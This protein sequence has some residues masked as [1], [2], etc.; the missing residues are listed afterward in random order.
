MMV[1]SFVIYVLS[2][3]NICYAATLRDTEPTCGYESCPAVKDDMIN[4][5]LV[6]HTHDDVGW[7]KTVDQYYYGARNNIQNAG[8]QY[9]LDSVIPELLNDP[10]KRFIY[11]E[12]AFFARWWR[13]QDD[14]MRHIVKGL[15]NSGR[16]EFILGG[17][18]MNDEASTHYNAIIDQ[19][20]LGFE[21]LRQNFGECGRP[22]IGWQIDPFGHSREQASL[23]AQFGFDGLFFGRLDF[24][25]KEERMKELTMEM[26]W[27]GSPNNLGEKSDLFTGVLFNGYS[28]PGGFCFDIF[29]QDEPIKDNKQLHDYNVDDRVKDFIKAV[30]SQAIHYKTNHI[31]MTMGSDFQYQ[32][33]HHWYKNMDKL[34]KYTNMLQ[35]TNHSNINVL[36]STPSCYLNQLNKAGIKWP[37]K[38]DDFFPYAHRNHSFWTGYFTSRAALKGYVRETNAF[39]QACKQ[40]DAIAML[41]EYFNTTYEIQVLKEAMGVAQHHDAVSGTEKQQVAYDYAE[42]LSHGRASCQRVMNDAFM[43]LMPKLRDGFPGVTWCDLMNI[44]ACN[45]TEINKKF[46]MVVYN[47]LGHTVTRWMRLPVVADAY[48]VNGPQNEPIQTQIIPVD[49]RTKSIPE[50]KGHMA[51]YTL[52]FPVSVPPLGFSTYFISKIPSYANK[53]KMAKEIPRKIT[54]SKEDKIVMKNEHM[55][56]EFNKKTGTLTKLRNLG[57][58]VDLDIQQ[59]IVFYYGHPGNCSE[60]DFQP[61]GAYIFRP[62]NT[63]PHVWQRS[64]PGDTIKGPLVQE[65]YTVFSEWV[66]QVTRLYEGEKYAEIEWTV[67]PIPIDDKYGKEVVA[68]FNT[69]LASNKIF[70]TDANGREVLMR[71]RNYRPTWKLNQTEPVAGNYYPVNSRIYIQDKEKNV[72]FTVMTDR[73]EG[74]ASIYDGQIELMLHRRLLYDDCLGVAEPL[75][76]TGSDGKGLIVRGKMLILMDTIDNSAKMHRDLGLKTYMAPIPS[77]AKTDYKYSEYSQYY[78]TTWSGLTA[79]LPPNVHLLTLE[80]WKGPAVT[81]STSQPYLIRLE[82]IY[83]KDE[84][85]ELSKPVTVSIQDMFVRFEIESIEELTLGANLLLSDLHRLKWQT[86]NTEYVTDNERA[87]KVEKLVSLPQTIQIELSPMEI[88]TFQVTLKGGQPTS[89]IDKFTVFS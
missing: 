35:E 52:V 9:V 53:K 54:N 1:S 36:Y 17:W 32:D 49:D 13:E 81:P 29:C 57:N 2:V 67:G 6:P 19:H 60:S 56:L 76:E 3:I 7:L 46:V 68:R 21:F 65:I 58:G 86:T 55:S 88:R 69:T 78:H 38:S 25:D 87:Y 84:D 73:S 77:F 79:P 82:H 39:L 11:V 50:R 23:F 4:V 59:D 80:Q 74:G 40:L 26:L 34:I 37:T 64:F 71:E 10:S 18:C 24:E 72:Q 15:V 28:P 22:R 83:E 62:N 31:I 66:T 70:Y 43:Q 47:P 20:A 5:H 33:A 41:D 63:T 44:S 12:I 16:L 42:R 51:L 75:N 85:P 89:N 8:V 61:S 48:T 45:H 27:H 14:S 30:E